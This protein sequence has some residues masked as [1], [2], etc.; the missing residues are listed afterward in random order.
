M[1]LIC[2]LCLVLVG[3]IFGFHIQVSE[4]AV[5]A[6]ASMGSI[7]GGMGAAGAAYISYRSTKEWKNEFYHGK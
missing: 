2:A 6:L 4:S 1:V 3:L 7:L 5:S